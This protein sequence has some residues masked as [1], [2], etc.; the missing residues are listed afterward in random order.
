MAQVRHPKLLRL[1]PARYTRV[2]VA[3]ANEG[4]SQQ[5]FI[6]SAIDA[7]LTRAAEESPLLN[8]VFDYLPR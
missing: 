7:A 6:E 5:A 2:R 8:F 4:Q 3:A 1:T